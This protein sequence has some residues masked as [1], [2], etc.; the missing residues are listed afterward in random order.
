VEIRGNVITRLQKLAQQEGIDALLLAAAGLQRLNFSI[1]GD[2]RLTGD[3][4][5]EGLRATVLPVEVMLP[6]VG[7]AAL[8]LETRAGDAWVS[9]ICQRLNHYTTFQCVA[10]ERAFLRAMGGGCQS[11]L[12]AHATASGE[13]LNLRA[14]SFA[15]GP[16]R[17]V[18]GRGDIRRPDELGETVAAQLGALRS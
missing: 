16:A 2:G 3:A 14:V 6:C 4:V 10:A 7:Q 5:P 1:A 9:A 8:G 17:A 18:A 12:A 13:E 11:P 15:N